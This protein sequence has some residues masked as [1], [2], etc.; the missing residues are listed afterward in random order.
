MGK[1]IFVADTDPH[2]VAAERHGRLRQWSRRKIGHRDIEI[3]EQPSQQCGQRQ[4]FA[5]R[6]ELVFSV[7]RLCLAD[8]DRHIVVR[9]I[10]LQ[11]VTGQRAEQKIRFVIFKA[12]QKH[13]RYFIKVGGQCGL[14]PDNEIHPRERLALMKIGARDIAGIVTLPFVTQ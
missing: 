5:K 3:V 1:R 12:C 14:G 8:P 11:R 10:L 6:H 2:G 7:K 4:V 13:G 9:G